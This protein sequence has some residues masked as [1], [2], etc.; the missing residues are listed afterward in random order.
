M[1]K[2]ADGSRA[3]IGRESAIDGGTIVPPAPSSGTTVD[4][5]RLETAPLQRNTTVPDERWD[6]G[7][8]LVDRQPSDRRIGAVVTGGCRP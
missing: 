8:D 7:N 4:R 5:F 3:S 1:A 6:G 2:D